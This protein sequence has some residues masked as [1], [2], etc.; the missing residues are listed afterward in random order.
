MIAQTVLGFLAI[1]IV[2]WFSR[3]REFRADAGS[4]ELVGADKM[5]AAL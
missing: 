3:W 2:R 4:A 1:I 5:I